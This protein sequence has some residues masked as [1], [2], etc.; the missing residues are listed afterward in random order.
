M[1]ATLRFDDVVAGLRAQG[2]A[3]EVRGKPRQSL[4]PA[5]LYAP[6]PGGFYFCSAT[7]LPKDIV[8]SVALVGRDF[9]GADA[10]G[11]CVIVVDGDPQ[12]IYYRLL[13]QRFATPS[14]G[15]IAKTAIVH[16]RA[17][18]GRTVQIDDYAVIGACE[19]GDDVVIGSHVV[20]HDG[21]RIGAGTVVDSHSIIGARGIAW[22]WT[23]DQSEKILQPQLGGVEIGAGC[24]LGANTIIVRGSLSDTTTI[25]DGSYLAPGCRLG[26]GTILGRHVHF[27]NGV[28]TG[29][30]A[31]VGD[32]SF[33]GSGAVLR[34][35][36]RIHENSVVGAGAVVVKDTTGPGLTLVGVP[37]VEHPTKSRLIGMPRP[38]STRKAR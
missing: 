29:G 36:A 19:L 2:V 35:K 37:A 38:K 12:L 18:V 6:I 30:N 28:L 32:Y 5:S 15:R 14:T 25:G 8:D 23:E 21:T 3:C 22:A 33:L 17:R 16:D 7:M 27:A 9:N 34:S 13:Q 31:R 24:I 11:N 4:R 20:I 26:H 1:T 10:G